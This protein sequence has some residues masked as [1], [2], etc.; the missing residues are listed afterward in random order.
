MHVEWS[1]LLALSRFVACSNDREDD[2]ENEQERRESLHKNENNM[3]THT[4]F[5]MRSLGWRHTL[6]W[7][8]VERRANLALDSLR[9]AKFRVVDSTTYQINENLK[10]KFSDVV[11]LKEAKIEIKEFVDYL[12]VP[13]K[14]TV[15]QLPKGALLLGP[16]GCGKTLLAKAVASEAN[17]PFLATNGTEFVEMIGGLGAAR[18]RDLFKE[19]KRRA[20]CMIYIDEIDAIGRRRS[21]ES[22]EGAQVGNS[23]HEHTLNQ[24]LVEMDGMD[25]SK[26]V[27]VLA[28]TNRA[29]ILDKALLRRGRF[30]RHIDIDLPTLAEREEIFDYYLRKVKL[31]KEPSSYSKILAKLTPGF[32]GPEKRSS[33]VSPE[34]KEVVAYHE[35]GHALVGWLLKH[36]NALLKVTIV[37]RTSTALGFAQYDP[38]DKK[39]YSQDDLSDRMCMALAGR[40][41][42][43]VVFNR[44]TT[45]ADNDL[46][47][48]TKIAYDQVKHYGM[49]PAVGPLSF[50]R[51]P[52]EEEYAFDKPFS[53]SLGN[54]ID[55]EASALVMTAYR[56]AEQILKANRDKLDLLA[57]SLLKKETLTYDEVCQ[58]IGPPPHGAKKT[59]ELIDLELPRPIEDEGAS[60]DSNDV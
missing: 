54:L 30:D 20:P 56:R 21:G 59:T 23:E 26:G 34:E 14:F 11:G 32:S 29:D 16:P 35:C 58:L 57:K 60:T 55:K 38:Q 15:R 24:L 52:G 5:C 3:R 36:T 6:Y 53:K 48:V 28:S 18:V 42:E 22:G 7:V 4:L 1:G 27:V 44:I 47:K 37:P 51:P 10:I 39:L 41:A 33:T 40:A 43:N 25:S 13:E 9:K 2:K 17:V 46:K 49:S 45:G 31:A 8:S 50:A 19:A 12:K